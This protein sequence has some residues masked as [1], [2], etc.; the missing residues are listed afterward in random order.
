MQRILIFI[1]FLSCCRLYAQ[2]LTGRVYDNDT[3]QP[4]SNVHVYLDGTAINTM[5]DKTG[6]FRLEVKQAINTKLVLRHLSYSTMII[7]NP[8]HNLPEQFFMKEQSNILNEVIVEAPR[9]S[10]EQMLKAFREQ[11]LGTSQA[12]K[13]CKIINEGDILLWYNTQTKTLS[14][15]SAQPVEVINEFLGY[16]VLFTLV[17]FWV[18]YSH[19]TLNTEAINQS[20]FAVL[21][22]YTDV[23]QDN[24]R[25][26]TRRDDTYERSSAFFFKN[27]TNKTL[28]EA[29][30][31][32]YKNGFP[33]DYNLCFSTEDTL[34]QKKLQLIS[35]LPAELNIINS[36]DHVGRTVVK[37]VDNNFVDQDGNLVTDPNLLDFSKQIL[38]SKIQSNRRFSVMFRKKQSDIQF[39][40]NSLLVD[41]Y[42]NID[43]IDKVF[44][45][46]LLGQNRAGDMLPLEYEPYNQ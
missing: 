40:T 21:S 39:S 44:F 23:N 33:A 38:E 17:D 30:F 14:A 2:T 36:D 1:I 46:G 10:R 35:T 32:F 13:S 11:F 22:S 18:V 12:G 20:Y 8:F 4:I 34:A 5:T 3:K 28:K 24:R 9:F 31:S 19:I 43:Q 6:V 16:K 29:G 7:E 25:M 41:Q 27:L 26:K 42:G 45:S 15:Y 37:Y